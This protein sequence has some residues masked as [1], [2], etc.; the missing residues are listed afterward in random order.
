MVRGRVGGDMNYF[1]RRA[2]LGRQ[3]VIQIDKERYELLAQARKTLVDAGSFEEHYEL[4]LGNFAAFEMYAAEVALRNNLEADWRYEKFASVLSEGNRH[5]INF[6]AT[7]RKY[8]DQVVR[9]FKHLKLPEPFDV[10]A[11]RLLSEAYDQALAYRFVCELRNFVQHRAVAVHGTKGR[12]GND[13]WLEGTMLY[14][15]KKYLLEDKGKFKQKVLDELDDIIDLL[16]MFRLYMASVSRVHLALGKHIKQVCI[17]ARQV[18][19]Q[20]RDEFAEAQTNEDKK[21]NPA[22]GLTAV[23]G[24]I[25]AYTD[26]VV[27]MLDWD[28]TRVLLTA[29]NCRLITVP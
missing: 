22:T 11:K 10:L 14:C 26:P 15:Q 4:L 5:A 29:K 21:S 6:L 13:T 20:A 8:A 28:D 3:V 27:L 19:Q 12:S 2:T 24:E 18:I 7:T 16:A 1:L 23:K 17:G 9:D 25:D